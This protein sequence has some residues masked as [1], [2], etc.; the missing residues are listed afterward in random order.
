[1]TQI[2]WKNA[3]S[4]DWWAAS[5]WNP[6]QIPGN[7]DAVTIG[8]SGSYTITVGQDPNNAPEGL[9]ISSL[10]I[11][12]TLASLVVTAPFNSI[13]GNFTNAGIVS[14]TG[15][16]N[17]DS[18][19]NNSGSIGVTNSS[20]SI[21]HLQNTGAIVATNSTIVLNSDAAPATLSSGTLDLRGGTALEYGL[22]GKITAI[23]SSATLLLSNATIDSD[24]LHRNND[25]LSLLSSNAGHLAFG[26][27][28]PVSNH[29][30]VFNNSGTYEIYNG[31]SAGTN[32][33][34]NFTNSGVVD[35][36]THSSQ[37]GST[38]D[39]GGT[40]ANSGTLQV[41]AVDGSLSASSAVTVAHMNNTGTINLFGEDGKKFQVALVDTGDAAPGTLATGVFLNLTGDAL[42]QYASGGIGSI[43]AGAG[44][45]IAGRHAFVADQG[46]AG[47]NSALVGLASNA[48][49]LALSDRVSLGNSAGSF[50]N[51]GTY[52][53][54]NSVV[55][56]TNL[57]FTNSGQLI[58][59]PGAG[60]GGSAVKISGAL[61]NS[62]TL[63]VGSAA[64]GLSDSVTTGVLDNTGTIAITGNSL[65]DTAS[66]NV[67]GT[68]TNAGSIDIGAFGILAQVNNYTQ[69]AGE[70]DVTGTLSG[71]KVVVAGGVV[72]G[73]GTIVANVS[74]T[75]GELAG[76]QFTDNLIGTLT[77]Q[78]RLSIK[79]TM[80]AL[81]IAAGGGESSQIDVS[82][83]FVSL[84][85]G[86]L[87]VNIE[88]PGN[89]VLGETFTVLNFTPGSLTHHFS[90]IKY[91]S[92]VGDGNGVDLGGGLSVSATY[93]NVAGKVVLTVVLTPP[94]AASIQVE[95]FDYSKVHQI[96]ASDASSTFGQIGVLNILD[97]STG[98]AHE[99][100]P[101][102]SDHHLL[103]DDF[104]HHL[105][106]GNTAFHCGAGHD[107]IH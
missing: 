48:G 19:L 9:N 10:T 13:T 2:S 1:M 95:S 105:F 35:I 98:Q 103:I 15:A 60:Q 74:V 65:S 4:G 96:D 37:G 106:G 72:E 55:V 67:K 42:L 57:D 66:L 16:L 32:A 82:G 44:L 17:V 58:L 52:T 62:G 36:D 77:V 61:H 34:L 70:T 83:T 76:G 80:D 101:G 86:T 39:V 91:G 64:L 28:A 27:A 59:D 73:A 29:G 88:D 89:L 99:T 49:T 22:G 93:D 75:T 3:V 20:W 79:G 107:F 92:T 71:S 26:N 68:A 56:R 104:L 69:T 100:L 53:I 84:K 33:G 46:N 97:L 24:L 50:T 45:S 6:G 38:F 87:N 94:H 51:S 14:W 23:G 90:A 63:D 5:N 30:V 41:G 18:L 21:T 31:V 81:L 25:I 40:F 85:G 102:S 8:V 78:G 54:F 12:D 7:F 11:S 47:I 43:A